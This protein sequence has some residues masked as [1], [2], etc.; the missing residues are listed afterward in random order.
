MLHAAWLPFHQHYEVPASGVKLSEWRTVLW[1]YLAIHALLLFAVLSWL[2]F[3]TRQVFKRTAPENED[4]GGTG[5]RGRA[6]PAVGVLLLALVG[7]AFV[8]WDTLREWLTAA[9]LSL[10]VLCASV[11]ALGWLFRSNE[12]AAPVHL[13]CWLCSSLHWASASAWTS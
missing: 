4:A 3:E 11:V 1:Q 9:L 10:V 13:P 2:V 6:V 8:W 7:A 5:W 12:R